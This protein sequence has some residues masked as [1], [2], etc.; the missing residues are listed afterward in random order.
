MFF[1]ERAILIKKSLNPEEQLG[2]CLNVISIWKNLTMKI[3]KESLL[4]ENDRIY[5]RPL[6]VKDITNEYIRGLND[7]EINRYLEVRRNVQTRES[8]EKFV[9]SNMEDQ[10]S[11]LFGIFI[12]NSREPFIGTIRAH[13]IDFFHY[14][15]SV[16]ICV[17]AKRAWKKG[18]AL[19]ALK[20]VKDYLFGVLGLHYLEAGAYAKNINSIKVFTRAGFAEWYRVKDKIR[21]INS[22]EE[23]I[24]FSAINTSFD[25]SLLK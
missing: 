8:V 13:G 11:I 22:F 10:S 2:V 14:T 7:L 1:S 12:K 3:D 19:Q 20:L 15:A 16:G 18:Y 21:L 17:F 9:I 6:R 23:G 24:F 4:L 5:L 25:T